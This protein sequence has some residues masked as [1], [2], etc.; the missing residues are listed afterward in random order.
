MKT[1]TGCDQSL[2]IHQNGDQLITGCDQSLVSILL[3]NIEINQ[4]LGLIKVNLL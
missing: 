1:I 4:S 3:S 2:V